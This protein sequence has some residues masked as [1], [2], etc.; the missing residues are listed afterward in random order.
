MPFDFSE[1]PHNPDGWESLRSGEFV[2]PNQ[3][4]KKSS[5]ASAAAHVFLLSAFP[6]PVIDVMQYKIILNES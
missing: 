1:Y 2:L 4:A 5:T 6:A 3:V